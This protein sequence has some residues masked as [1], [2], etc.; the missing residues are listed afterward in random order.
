MKVEYKNRTVLAIDFQYNDLETLAFGGVVKQPITIYTVESLESHGEIK[1]H[2]VRDIKKVE[3][4]F[5]TPCSY[6]EEKAARMEC[7]KMFHE[8]AKAVKRSK[9]KGGVDR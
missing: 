8:N 7:L 2:Q 1:E 6:F 5:D 9:L 3:F 4:T